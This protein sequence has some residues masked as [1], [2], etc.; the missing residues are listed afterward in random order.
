MRIGEV[1]M[2]EVTVETL[3]KKDVT[4]MPPTFDKFKMYEI[5]VQCQESDI[6]F[7]NDNYQKIYGK[8]PFTLREDF[9]GTAALACDWVKQSPAHRSWAI[10][11]DPEPFAYGKVNHFSKLTDNQKDRVTF[12]EGNVLET[13]SYKTDV[14]VAFNFSY[15]V[16]KKRKELLEYFKKVREGLNPEGM[17]VI[18]LFGGTEARE[19]MVEETEHDNF[20]YFWDCESYNP[21]T[22]ECKYAI[23]FKI[24]RENKK[25]HNVFNYDWRLWGIAELREVM[26]DAGFKKTRAFWEG[27][28][29]D[30]GGDGN[31][32]VTEV[33]E[34]CESWVTYIVATP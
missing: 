8:S 21:I 1:S 24:H 32:Y 33:G 30:G 9:A 14:I 34:P 16:F 11:L 3:K 10:D 27:D 12:I 26:E 23:H 7:V 6:D 4:K 25:Y 20:S 31:F 13:Q 17:F 29:E 5:S 28:D 2:Q 22:H 15:F 19:A 18:D